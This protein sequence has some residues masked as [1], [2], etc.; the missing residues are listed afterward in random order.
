M[1]RLIRISLVI[2]MLTALAAAFGGWVGVRVGVRQAHDRPGLDAVVHD[3]LRLTGPQEARIRILE[4]AFA[5]RR[6]GLEA[7]M[8]AAN[9]DLASAIGAEHV[10]GPRAQQAVARFHAAMGALQEETIRHV[11]AMRGV[12]TPDQARQFDRLIDK[13]LKPPPA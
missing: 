7:E 4:R 3:Q 10:Y 5:Y 9:S 8:R 1:S 2:A 11:L 6:K 13:A 12:M